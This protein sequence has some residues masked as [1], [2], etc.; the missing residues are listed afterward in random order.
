MFDGNI[1]E[2]VWAG[3]Q[4]GNSIGLTVRTGQSGDFAVSNDITITNNVLKNVVWFVNGTAL[5]DLCGTS[6]YPACTNPGSQAR[7]N[8]SNNLVTFYDPTVM[9]GNRNY[10]LTLQPS[11][12]HFTGAGGQIHDIVFQHNTMVQNGSHP[13]Y[14]GVYFGTGILVAPNS[15]PA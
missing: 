4:L 10:S 1:I 11:L 15:T 12:N 8:I 5:D 14:A 9:G 13:C 7:W 3:G 2:N 6:S